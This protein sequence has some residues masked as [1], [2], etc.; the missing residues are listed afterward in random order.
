MMHVIPARHGAALF[1]TVA[2]A[3]FLAAS[4]GIAARISFRAADAWSQGL[5]GALTVRIIAPDSQ[6][7]VIQVAERLRTS[8]GIF[9]ARA[10]TPEDAA[11]LLNE[12]GGPGIQ[13]RDLPPLRLIEL[14]VDKSQATTGFAHSL[15]HQ[16][17][18]VG[19]QAEVYGP[20]QWAENWASATIGYRDIGIALVLALGITALLTA[21]L[22]GRARAA[23]DRALIPPLADMG[24]SRGQVA[25]LF[26]RRGAAEGFLAG[27]LGTAFAVAFSGVALYDFLP[28]MPLNDWAN[29]FSPIDAAPVVVTPFLAALLVGAGARAAANRAYA[30]AARLA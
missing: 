26:A 14:E 16:L 13:A 28:R 18:A 22:V 15:E 24:A 6:E 30:R 21:G 25:G 5:H 7:A 19:Y 23:A 1:W 12:W 20:G 2:I 27:L 9:A 4:A 17:E 8:P 11:K 29:L 3:C 10:M